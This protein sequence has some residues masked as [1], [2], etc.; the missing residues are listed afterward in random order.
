MGCRR[1]SRIRHE[2]GLTEGM[3]FKYFHQLSLR[4][5]FAKRCPPF[6]PA[7]YQDLFFSFFFFIS[8]YSSIQS[9]CRHTLV[10]LMTPLL[11]LLTSMIT[12]P[13]TA[14]PIGLRNVQCIHKP[15]APPASII[16]CTNLLRAMGRLPS[17]HE[18]LTYATDEVLEAGLASCHFELRAIFPSSR[19]IENIRLI[20]YFPALQQISDQ[21]LET[22]Q[23]YN[24]GQ[25]SVGTY[26]VA[27]L[28]PEGLL[29]SARNGTVV[30]GGINNGSSAETRVVIA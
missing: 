3:P 10:M 19:Q 22:P 2:H 17:F 18:R 21:C 7:F 9:S 28:G 11:V 16:D 26:F 27:A 23:G 13:S 24:G 14:S 12:L 4:F 20:E 6:R 25:I 8:Y 5:C 29:G 30:H 15:S 1:V